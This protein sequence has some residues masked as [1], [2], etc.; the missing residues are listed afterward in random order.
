MNFLFDTNIFLEV[1]LGQEKQEF[2]KQILVDYNGTIFISEFSVHSIGVIL[3]RQKKFTF[4]DGFMS[5]ITNNG[6]IITLPWNMYPQISII[7]QKHQLDFDDSIQMAIALK[8]HL[9]IITMDGD[10]KKVAK[11]ITIRFI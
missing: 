4:F 2:C 6:S 5:D 7:S 3:F 10:F 11:D 1:L 9:G 8:H